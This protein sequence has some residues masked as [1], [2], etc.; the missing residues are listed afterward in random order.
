MKVLFDTN[1]ILDFALQREE[2]FN[3]AIKLFEL[4]ENRTIKAYL[5]ATTITDIYYITK[6]I[7]DYRVAINFIKSL[8]NL[9]EVLNIDKR[10]IVKSL[11][12]D[13]PDFED[14]VQSMAANF[15]G[16]NTIITRN[17]KDFNFE[18]INA[19]TPKEFLKKYK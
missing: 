19:L 6:K 9:F 15:N 2:H 16:V 17:V 4:I 13:S 5:T 1:I 18:G 8:V 12:L 14:S 10:V 7:K 11:E 3:F